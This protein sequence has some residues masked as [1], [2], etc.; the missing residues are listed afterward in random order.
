MI[1]AYFSDITF[2]GVDTRC[3]RGIVRSPTPCA[4]LVHTHPPRH[5]LISTDVSG[6]TAC[7]L[8][9]AVDNYPAIREFNKY[10]GGGFGGIMTMAA[11]EEPK[12]VSA[13]P[14]DKTA[15]EEE[16]ASNGGTGILDAT[17]DQQ[18]ERLEQVRQL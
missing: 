12:L 17:W 7:S 18:L 9:R 6:L 4:R 14:A 3:P 1:L 5:N 11:K 16:A 2:G 8:Q 10:S 15:E 13:I